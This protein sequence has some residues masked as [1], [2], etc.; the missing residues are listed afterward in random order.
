MAKR[1]IRFDWAIK[2]LLRNKANFSILEGF[3]SVLLDEPVKIEQVLESESNRESENDR[4]N[5]VDLLVQNSKGEL[6]IIE[7]QNS[8]EVD[9]FHRMVYG[10]AKV[11]SEHIQKGQQY[12]EGKKVIS[13]TI[14]YFDIGQGK[15]YV[16]HGINEFRGLHHH[17]VLRLAQKQ[18]DLY[19]K[20]SVFE[21]F[22][23]YWIIKADQFDDNVTDKLDEWIYFLKHSAVPD[24]FT[25]P[26]LAEAQERL[27]E[28]LMSEDERR[29]YHAYMERLRDIAS[30]HYNRKV[31]YWWDMKQAKLEGKVEVAK[32]LIN[33]G[34]DNAM[35]SQMTSLTT[36]QIDALREGMT[37]FFW[38]YFPYSFLISPFYS[39][40]YC[41]Q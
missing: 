19:K 31:D 22:P 13:I 24:H 15:D 34:F 14:A 33:G 38:L 20:Q 37:W 16:Y 25:A 32:N 35:I 17:D 6:I 40:C 28:M 8:K 18:K 41:T 30:E 39:S 10:A 7:V 21:V 4:H 27:D 11:V 9:Y 26:G 12:A 23:E 36:E 3:L 5:R 29:A 2:K 1:L